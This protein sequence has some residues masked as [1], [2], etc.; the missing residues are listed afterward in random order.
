MSTDS[1]EPMGE[2]V[3]RVTTIAAMNKSLARSNKTAPGRSRTNQT[4]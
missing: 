3:E 4:C 2:V 1:E